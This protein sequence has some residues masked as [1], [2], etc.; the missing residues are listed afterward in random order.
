ML[1]LSG[2]LLL[3]HSGF[4]ICFSVFE[5]ISMRADSFL[6]SLLGIS[7][8]RV[9]KNIESENL[10]V[11]GKTVSKNNFNKFIKGAVI[12]FELEPLEQISADPEEM[13]LDIVFENDL[14]LIVNKPAG[15]VVHPGA[16]NFSGTLVNG[17]VHYLKQRNDEFNVGDPVRPG[18]VHRIDKDTSGLLVVAKS[19]KSF[20]ELSKKFAKHD[21]EREYTCLVWGHLKDPKGSIK[22]FHGRDPLNRLRFSPNAKNG[23]IAVSHYEVVAEYRFCSL[24]K[25]NLETGRTH[26]IRMHM[27]SIGHSIINDSLYGGAGKADDAVFNKL[28]STSGRQL[29]HAGKLGFS[30]L[31]K[32]YSFSSKVPDDIKEIIHYLE[33][34]SAGGIK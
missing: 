22:T 3:T 34:I 29:L 6:S 12:E 5:N 21:I 4:E 33:K 18:L 28:L 7:R 24:L 13:D 23:K 19:I 16:G 17:I 1:R 11:N 15:I 32:T 31:G 14:F 25:V 20:E 30:I 8:T 26:Q 27:K 2:D 10:S 9:Q